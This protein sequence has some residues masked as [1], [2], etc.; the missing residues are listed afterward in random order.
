MCNCLACLL[1]AYFGVRAR[2]IVRKLEG[3]TNTFL[4]K[5][6]ICRYPSTHGTDTSHAPAY[7]AVV[8]VKVHSVFALSRLSV[9]CT[10]SISWI[11]VSVYA[12]IDIIVEWHGAL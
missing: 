3:E 1:E 4:I 6:F 8:L 9:L 11:A 2:H 12:Y 10:K 7:M 5:I